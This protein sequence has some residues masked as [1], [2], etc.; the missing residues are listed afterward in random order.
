MM[1]IN[2][3]PILPQN[4]TKTEVLIFDR[5]SSAKI[6]SFINNATD[7]LQKYNT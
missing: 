1:Q 6:D 2:V 3:A 4:K 5:E 7:L